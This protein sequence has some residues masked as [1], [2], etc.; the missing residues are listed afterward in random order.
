ML[1]QQRRTA[2]VPILA[3]DTQTTI[4]SRGS[5][6]QHASVPAAPALSS[7]KANE[8]SKRKIDKA[9]VHVNSK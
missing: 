6:G 3:G 8:Q 1:L 7:P 4:Y 9:S 2:L 5:S